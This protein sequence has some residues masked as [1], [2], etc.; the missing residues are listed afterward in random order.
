VHK[1]A[2]LALGYNFSFFTHTIE[3]T[4]GELIRFC[5]EYGFSE[6]PNDFIEL[7]YNGEFLGYC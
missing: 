4:S 2:L 5:F 6:T 7:R 1:D 3:T